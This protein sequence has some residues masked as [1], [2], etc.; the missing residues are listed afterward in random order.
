MISFPPENSAAQIP[1]RKLRQETLSPGFPPPQ[2][3]APVS[4][5]SR[6][7]MRPEIHVIE[8]TSYQTCITPIQRMRAAS[9]WS[10]GAYHYLDLVP[11]GRDEGDQGPSW[12]RRHD[13]YGR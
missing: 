8:T 13:E 11:K 5:S 12:L 6:K 2:P 10:M 4:L 9:T 7:P 1:C 3:D